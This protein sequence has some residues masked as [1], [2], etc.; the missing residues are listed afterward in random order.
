M[1][2]S[3]D[4]EIGSTLLKVQCQYET[5]VSMLYYEQRHVFPCIDDYD[6]EMNYLRGI[7]DYFLNPIRQASE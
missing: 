6:D 2:K 7:S 4:Y 5:D 3:T 1:C